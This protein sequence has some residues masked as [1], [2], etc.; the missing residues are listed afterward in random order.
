MR[1]RGKSVG[2]AWNAHWK[3]NSKILENDDTTT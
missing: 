1:S 2:S 3:K